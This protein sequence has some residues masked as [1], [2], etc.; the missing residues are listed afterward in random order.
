[1]LLTAAKRGDFVEA[2]LLLATPFVTVTEVV[3]FA[4]LFDYADF[5]VGFG[6]L[7]AAG[8]DLGFDRLALIV[9]KLLLGAQ[10]EFMTTGGEETFEVDTTGEAMLAGVTAKLAKIGVDLGATGIEN[11][12]GLDGFGE[13]MAALV[14]S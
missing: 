2:L 14:A 11:F 10:L 7:M 9:E 1:M 12:G 8:I 3:S 5:A 13:T 6:E 4:E